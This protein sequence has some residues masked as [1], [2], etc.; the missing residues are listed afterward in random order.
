[1]CYIKNFI[2]KSSTAVKYIVGASIE[3]E[4]SNPRQDRI[5]GI[6]LL[7]YDICTMKCV[8]RLNVRL[9]PDGASIS[10][11]TYIRS[12]VTLEDLDGCVK[13]ADVADKVISIIGGEETAVV[14]YNLR[15]F[16]IPFIY[17]ETARCAKHIDFSLDKYVFDIK[18]FMDLTGVYFRDIQTMV[19]HC[20]LFDPKSY[21]IDLATL[22]GQAKASVVIFEKMLEKGVQP[23]FN[24]VYD[25]QGFIAYK[26]MWNTAFDDLNGTVQLVFTAG[27]YY[28]C[29]VN[30]VKKADPAYI[31]WCLSNVSGL[32]RAVKD[33]LARDC[34]GL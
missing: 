34:D 16:I 27:K 1:M 3:T 15:Q 25:N 4:N 10:L 19:R 28:G 13:W 21:G 8:S 6:C 24:F 9:K 20:N 12:G 14:G 11:K 22:P 17:N 32:S 30:A 26:R 18:D 31:Q 29:P 2:E 5:I 7:K 23:E 33:A